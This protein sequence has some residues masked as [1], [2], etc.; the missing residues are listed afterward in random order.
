M[1]GLPIAVALEQATIDDEGVSRNIRRLE[2]TM[3]NLGES[4]AKAA[5]NKTAHVRGLTAKVREL[6]RKYFKLR[7]DYDELGLAL[8]REREVTREVVLERDEWKNLARHLQRK[9]G[10]TVD[11]ETSGE[12]RI[13][14]R[15]TAVVSVPVHDAA[16]EPE[17]EDA[18]TLVEESVPIR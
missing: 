8:E 4:I 17:N 10:E 11:G 16:S 6:K 12:S 3:Y 14:S 2:E 13:D 9:Y 15:D 5:H 18:S 7:R 1:A